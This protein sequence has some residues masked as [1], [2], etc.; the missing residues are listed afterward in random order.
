MSEP[1]S[2]RHPRQLAPEAAEGDAAPGDLIAVGRVVD[3]YGLRGWVK[4]EPYNAPEESVL[5]SCRRW[6]LPDGSSVAVERARQ[7]GAS[8]VCK[9]AGCGDREAALAFKGLELRAS[10]SEFPAAGTDEFYWVDLVGCRVVNREGVDLGEVDSVT[11]HGAHA[12]LVV[13]DAQA[14]ER[15]IPFVDA[16]VGEVDLAGRRVLVDWQPDY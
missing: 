5:R 6:W 3:A 13:R 10:R 1:G 15:L 7:H 11:D 8:I 9:P 16:Y 4:V 14:V 2:G 12:I